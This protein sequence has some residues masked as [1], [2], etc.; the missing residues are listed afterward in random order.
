MLTRRICLTIS[1][2][3]GQ[4]VNLVHLVVFV[5]KKKGT[6][7]DKP[8]PLP[9]SRGWKSNTGLL[10]AGKNMHWQLGCRW[11]ADL[12]VHSEP[13]GSTRF[14]FLSL[15]RP[16]SYKI[17]QMFR[18]KKWPAL[19]KLPFRSHRKSR[20]QRIE[21]FYNA[22]LYR[23]YAIFHVENAIFRRVAFDGWAKSHKNLLDS[24]P[25]WNLTTQLMVADVPLCC[26]GWNPKC[27]WDISW[28][29]YVQKSERKSSIYFNFITR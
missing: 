29:T 23:K 7:D 28:L 5:M 11:K 26:G 4:R 8:S 1:H 17:T 16:W 13:Q 21:P 24:L 14:L 27:W 15:L 10:S 18:I 12:P 20:S 9:S 25:T 2:S 22:Q 6:Y 19:F 3:Y